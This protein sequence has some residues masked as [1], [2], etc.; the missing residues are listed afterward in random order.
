MN[1]AQ[2]TI[3]LLERIECLLQAV[4]AELR[5]SRLGRAENASNKD[6]YDAVCEAN[7][8]INDWGIKRREGAERP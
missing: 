1:D 3:N 5:L 8:A 2:K 7:N 6:Q 4:A